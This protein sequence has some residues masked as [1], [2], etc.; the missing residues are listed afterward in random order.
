MRQSYGDQPSPVKAEASDTYLAQE[1][2][3]HHIHLH[4]VRYFAHDTSL[5]ETLYDVGFGAV[6]A[7]LEVHTQ[8]GDV[9]FVY[10][11]EH[12]PCAYV[13]VG[14]STIGGEGFLLQQ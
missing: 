8:D 6:L 7:E 12:G 14:M 9:A 1:W 13:I 5:Q 2:V 4:L 11:E 3:N 10:D